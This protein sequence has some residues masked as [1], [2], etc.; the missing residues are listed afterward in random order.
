MGAW[1]GT[2]EAAPLSDNAPVTSGIRMRAPLPVTNS[3]VRLSAELDAGT[4]ITS[5]REW[6]AR[7]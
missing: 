4:R 6:R 2:P 7:D 1:E 3:S 5:R